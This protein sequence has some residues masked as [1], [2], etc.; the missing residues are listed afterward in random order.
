[1]KTDKGPSPK[2]LMSKVK[3]TYVCGVCN[4]MSMNLYRGFGSWPTKE[5][6]KIPIEAQEQFYNDIKGKTG[7]DVIAHAHEVLARY[8]DKKE[9]YAANG[10]F[11]PL[12][13]WE[14]QGYDPERIKANATED[15]RS[16]DRMAGDTYKVPVKSE[17]KVTEIGFR[18]D[19]IVGSRKR[20]VKAADLAAFRAALETAQDQAPSDSEQTDSSSSDSSSSSDRKKKKKS[21]KKKSKKDKEKKR[22]QKEKA[23]ERESASNRSANNRKPIGSMKH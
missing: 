14:M 16:H 19:N 20:K 4:N 18:R 21:K 3:G 5:F 10:E 12:K 7:K 6:K 2:R 9:V 13:F 17:N 8:E 15:E 1:M 22:L 23:K 11:R